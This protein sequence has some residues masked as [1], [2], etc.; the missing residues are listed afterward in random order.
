L[1][2]NLLRD[3]AATPAPAALI[4]FILLESLRINIIFFQNASLWFILCFYN[5]DKQ[6]KMILFTRTTHINKICNN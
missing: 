1:Q 3:A 5:K 6:D 2:I 4:Y